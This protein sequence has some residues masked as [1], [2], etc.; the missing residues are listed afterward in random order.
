MT[1]T[2]A[3]V[4]RAEDPR[5]EDTGAEPRWWLS[6]DLWERLEVAADLRRTLISALARGL[7]RTQALWPDLRRVYAWVHQAA[8]IG[9]L[10]YKHGRD[11]AGLVSLS[12]FD[13][14]IYSI[15]FLV[16]FLVVGIGLS[17]GGPTGY[18]INPARDLGPRI[19]HA[20][21]PIAG[22]GGSDWG[23]AW[24]PVVAPIIGGILG[25]V[26]WVILF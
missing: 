19:A 20:V 1:D 7:E 23:Y 5:P 18:A 12:G 14:L 21:L 8:R 22:K 2:G 16:A 13:G 10:G 17:L 4:T 6:L 11:L 3:E 26:A 25:A 24:I 9:V 15:G